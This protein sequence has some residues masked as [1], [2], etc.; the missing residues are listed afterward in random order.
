MKM[1]MAVNFE[2][3][4][5]KSAINQISNIVDENMDPEHKLQLLAALREKAVA[6]ARTG[7]G[8][9]NHEAMRALAVIDKMMQVA[10]DEAAESSRVVR[11]AMIEAPRGLRKAM[12]F[13]NDTEAQ[14]EPMIDE[15]ALLTSS[16][17]D[18]INRKLNAASREFN[19][20]AEDMT[21]ALALG[22]YQGEEALKGVDDVL[23]KAR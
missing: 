12:S 9:V 5:A 1:A 23:T 3:L 7:E 14:V 10:E 11:T 22:E 20:T 13:L 2:A 15:A 8:E 16:I 21:G 18:S 17:D 4:D 19:K 6:A